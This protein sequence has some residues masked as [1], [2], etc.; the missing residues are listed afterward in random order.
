VSRKTART[1]AV[2]VG[3]AGAILIAAGPMF[4]FMPTDVG[5]YGAFVAI[6]IVVIAVLVGKGE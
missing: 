6:L 3:V 2:V 5:S 4:H 1:I